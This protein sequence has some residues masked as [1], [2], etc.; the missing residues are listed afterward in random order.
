MFLLDYGLQG[1]L[2][3]L[4]LIPKP[5]SELHSMLDWS[6]KRV[7]T[8]IMFLYFFGTVK[9]NCQDFMFTAALINS[10]YRNNILILFLFTVCTI[11]GKSVWMVTS[12]WLFRLCT[13]S[14]WM[15]NQYVTEVLTFRF[16]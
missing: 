13:P 1:Y 9:I 6:L 4:I 11:K 2:H 7:Q 16:I 15:L 3:F 12:C 14:Q 10:R 5:V 8:V